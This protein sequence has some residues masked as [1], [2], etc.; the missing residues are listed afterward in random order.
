MADPRTKPDAAQGS[1]ESS[2]NGADAQTAE[3]L[4][5][6]RAKLTEADKACAEYLALAQR[7][8]A[9]FENYQKRQA[10]DLA[11]ERRY[12]QTPLAHDL[13]TP[14]DNLDRAVAAAKQARDSGP[15]AQ[16]V[17]MVHGQLL[18]VLRRHG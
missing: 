1:P 16:G 7:V 6:L 11:E 10:R 17:Y 5:S 15:L 3:D 12:A 4:D 2:A 9:D 14:L 13:L 8:K 18:D